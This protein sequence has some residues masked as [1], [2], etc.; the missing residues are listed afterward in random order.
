MG[1]LQTV[2]A[3]RGSVT[4]PIESDTKQETFLDRYLG[5]TIIS[6]RALF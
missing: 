1:F 3:I 2:R 5:L 4:R 6:R